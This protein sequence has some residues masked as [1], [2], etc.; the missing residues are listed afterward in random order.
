MK[1][2]RKNKTQIALAMAGH[3]T[4]DLYASFI[5]GIIP[6]LAVKFNLSLFLVGLLT[7]ITGISNSLTQPV[8]GY[9]ADRYNPKYFLVLGPLLSAIFISVMP[10]MPTYPLV[11]VFLFIGNLSISLMHPPAAAAGGQFGGR[12]KGFSNSLIS[13][14]GTFGYAMGSFFIILIIEKLGINFSPIAMIPGIIA[15]IF[16]FKFLNFP[17]KK[18]SAVQAKKIFRK[19]RT[20]DKYKVIRLAF[21]FSASYSR[22]IFWLALLTFMPLYFTGAGIRLIDMGTIL[23]LFTL[24]GGIGGLIS[25]Y[26]SDK[27]KNKIIIIQLGL[28]FSSPFAFYIFRTSGAVPVLMFI[29]AGFFS[30]GTLPLCIRVSQDIFPANMGLASSMVMGLSVGTASITMIF[31]GKVADNIGIQQTVFYIII[32]NLVL[33]LLLTVYYF[34]PIRKEA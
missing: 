11:I 8:F 28:L 15:A 27:I 3:M 21:V 10:V 12:M 9:L 18:S 2:S 19:I 16:L 1:S 30:I 29:C 34:I 23:I 20:I 6:I 5:V 4:T 13:F 24:A 17:E 32:L 33:S 7:S 14:A 22:D 25:G 31:I 26:F